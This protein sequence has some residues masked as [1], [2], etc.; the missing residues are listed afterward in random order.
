MLSLF[1]WL[2]YDQMMFRHISVTVVTY[3]LNVGHMSRHMR[4]REFYPELQYIYTSIYFD[5][6]KAHHPLLYLLNH[7]LRMMLQS[8]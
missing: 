3:H 8:W 2:P 5:L 4:H 7:V 1:M 6:I